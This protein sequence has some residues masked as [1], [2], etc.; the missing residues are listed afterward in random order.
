MRLILG[1]MSIRY[2]ICVAK[3]IGVRVISQGYTV[4]F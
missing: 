3:L 4:V 2:V 1:C